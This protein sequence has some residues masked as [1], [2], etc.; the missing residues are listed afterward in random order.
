LAR[1]TEIR[2]RLIVAAEQLFSEQGIEGTSLRQIATAGGLVNNSAVQYHFGSKVG[3]IDAIFRQ[4]ME[5]M[6]FERARLLAEA[7]SKGRL[8]DIKTLLQMICHPHRALVDQSGRHP[9]AHFLCQYLLRYRPPAIPWLPAEVIPDAPRHLRRIQALIREK[10]FY[11]PDRLV[12]RRLVTAVIMYLSVLINHDYLNVGSADGESLDS[13]LDD[14]I[15]QMV[16][17]ISLPLRAE[18]GGESA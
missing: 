9:Y 3:L 1:A 5:E 17:A 7:E 18:P 8:G 15:E 11:L 6:E 10:L 13:M 16:A 2:Y 14:T 4:R 12:A